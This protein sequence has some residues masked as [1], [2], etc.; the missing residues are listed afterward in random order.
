[1]QTIQKKFKEMG[2]EAKINRRSNNDSFVIDIKNGQFDIL[3]GQKVNL[4]VVDIDPDM[5]HLLL[6][7]DANGQKSKYLCGHDERHWFVAS[8]PTSSASSIEK[9]M[10]SLK[11]AVVRDVENR[12]GL[13]SKKKNTRKNEAFRRQGE[14]FFLPNPNFDPGKDAVIFKNEPIRRGR[15][16]PHKCEFLT[17]R[18]GE[19]VSVHS[20]HAPN[21]VP[22]AE[23]EEG[24]RSGRWN[25]AAWRRMTRNASVWVKG[26]ISHKD[27]AT[28][29]LDCW[30]Q[31]QMNTEIDTGGQMA[32][33]D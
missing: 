24:V 13:K 3:A 28:I 29:V 2:A 33:L 18:G 4:Q 8:V 30:H 19:E 23:Y 17:R 9:A 22:L 25:T 26:K 27:H 5:R 31:V 7:V 12:V 14:W 10:E 15:G 20:R 32:F 6:H 21:G 16:K 11:P 1:M